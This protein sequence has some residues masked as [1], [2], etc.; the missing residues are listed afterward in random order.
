MFAKYFPAIVLLFFLI[1]CGTKVS[2]K[3]ES[4]TNKPTGENITE[5]KV[6]QAV[7][8]SFQYPIQAQGKIESTIEAKVFS[9]ITGLVKQIQ[10]T[11]KQYVKKGQVL[12]RL[13]NNEQV[14][15]L[16]NAKITLKEKEY[17]YQTKL[18][19]Y[20]NNTDKISINGRSVKENLRT[21]SGLESAAVAVKEAQLAL[22]YTVFRAPVSGVIANLKHKA[23]TQIQVGE[24]FCKIYSPKNL[25]IN[26]TVLESEIDLLETGRRAFVTTLSDSTN[27]HKAALQEIDPYVDENGMVSVKLKLQETK[28]LYPG[29]N[30]RAVIVMPFKKN[31]IISKDAV[32]IRSGRHVV[33]V[34]EE[35]LAKWKYVTIGR[36]NGQEVEIL[37]GLEEKDQVIVY[38]NL[39]L[40]HDSPVKVID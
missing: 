3:E 40:A 28:G 16:A 9:R 30:A 24:E 37:E 8:K 38:N 6:I 10:V 34:V 5:V 7:K 31:I 22:S 14:L 36:E 1:G 25:F 33:F 27:Q 15:A 26:A 11:N 23:F 2:D 12:A 18:L 35:N 19:E 13:D 17:E 20:G 29:M 39:Q 21:K 32:V 4:D